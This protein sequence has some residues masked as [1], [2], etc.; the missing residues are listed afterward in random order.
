MSF[1]VLLNV[2][3]PFCS[4]TP[5]KPIGDSSSTTSTRPRPIAAVFGE[6]CPDDMVLM[7]WCW[8]SASLAW[9]GSVLAGVKTSWAPCDEVRFVVSSLLISYAHGV[10]LSYSSVVS[11]LFKIRWLWWLFTFS[12]KINPLFNIFG[13]GLIGYSIL[14]C[15][16][17]NMSIFGCVYTKIILRIFRSHVHSSDS[18]NRMM[19][20]HHIPLL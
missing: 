18:S 11:K 1:G 16:Q 13:F 10:T 9:L 19:L 3:T 4:E 5:T 12:T 17:T 7:R 20:L 2:G 6:A 8:T 14:S 15:Q